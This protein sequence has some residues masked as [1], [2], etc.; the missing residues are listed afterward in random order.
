MPAAARAR[1]RRSCA[2]PGRHHRRHRVC[3]RRDGAAAR[4]APQRA[5]R[6]ASRVAVASRSRWAACIPIWPAPATRSTR[7]CQ[8]PTPS[9]WRSPT[10]WRRRRR[11]TSSR[12]VPRSS[13]RVP[14]SGSAIRPTIPAGTASSIRRRTCWPGPSTGCRSCIGPS[15]PRW[16]ARTS[17]SS[18]HPAAIPPRPSWRSRRSHVPG[19]SR[20]SWWTP[21][22]ASRVP[23]ATP[24]RTSTFSEVNESVSAYGIGGH[25]HVAE[26]EQELGLLSPSPDANPGVRPID[27]LPHLIPMTRGILSAGHVRPT[28]PV[29]TA[30]LRELYRDT[31]PRRAV[32]GG[33]GQR[34]PPP[35]T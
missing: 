35:S 15:W 3:R 30:E 23:A 34:H 9:S 11:A 19:S 16:V 1:A 21:R 32:R 27:F 14:T 7:R 18:A 13:T 24:S 5:H 26:M 6:R 22:A 33:D 28:R 2:H 31:Y 10:G 29:T 20:T 25:R 12:P 17:P 8:R 4:P